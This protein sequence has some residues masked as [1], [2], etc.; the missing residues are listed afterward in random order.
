MWSRVVAK[1]VG[2]KVLDIGS[3]LAMDSGP[4][5]CDLYFKTLEIDLDLDVEFPFVHG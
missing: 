5:F 4:F 3:V 1:N 2:I